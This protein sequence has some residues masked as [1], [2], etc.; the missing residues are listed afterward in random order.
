MRR[1]KKWCVF[2]YPQSP[3]ATAATT[4]ATD[5]DPADAGLRPR[6]SVAAC[7]RSGTGRGLR[8]RGWRGGHA[9]TLASAGVALSRLIPVADL[10]VWIDCE[11]TGLDLGKDAL[12]EV[13]ALVT[14][15]DLNVLGDGRRR[16]HP[17]RRRGARRHG[18][19]RARRCTR[20][21]ASPRRCARSTVTLAEAEDMVLEYVTTYVPDPRTRAAVRQLDRHR[22]RL[23]RPRHAAPRRAPALPHD[24]RLVDQGAVPALVPA[25]V[26][27][28]A[29]QGPGPPGAGRHPGEHPRAG[30]L[31][32]DDLRAAARPGRRGGQGDRGRAAEPPPGGQPGRRAGAGCGYHW[33]AP[34]GIASG[35]AHGG[36][37]SA[38]RAPGCGPGGRGFESR[39]SPQ[40]CSTDEGPVRVDRPSSCARCAARRGSAAVGPRRVA[41]SAGGRTEGRCPSRTASQLMF[42]SVQPL[43]LLELA[44]GALDGDRVADLGEAEQPGRVGQSTR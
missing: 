5:D 34:A 35:G 9:E 21:P 28:P 33:S 3:T 4:T 1:S 7:R 27:R 15:P 6:R 44:L 38:G 43:P 42:Q 16:G 39:R 40:P 8:R 37:S 41:C 12:I 20:S 17:R 30:V 19:G 10:L 29:G 24:R 26:L 22:P 23:H 2:P 25:G 36:C 13:A 18:R 11:M 32:A 14:D 31:P